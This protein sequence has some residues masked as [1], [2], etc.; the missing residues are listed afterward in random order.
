[1]VCIQSN[2]NMVKHQMDGF[3]YKNKNKNWNTLQIAIELEAIIV[4]KIYRKKETESMWN[5]TG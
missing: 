5:A 1:M 2:I 4:N 3:M